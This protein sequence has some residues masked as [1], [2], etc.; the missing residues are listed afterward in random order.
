ME[1]KN[2]NEELKDINEISESS[3]EELEDINTI[4]YICEHNKKGNLLYETWCKII[5]G[6]PK[7]FRE[8]GPNNIEY[9]IITGNI[10][11]EE[12]NYPREGDLPTRVIYNHEGKM[13]GEMWR[14][15]Y[16]VSHRENGWAEIHYYDNG[17]VD[18]ILW[19]RNGLYYN[20]NGPVCVK[21]FTNGNIK[22]IKYQN[23]DGKDEFT[24]EIFFFKNGCV[25]YFMYKKNGLLHK[26]NGPALVQYCE[27][28]NIR[29]IM[30]YTNNII[31]RDDG[32]AEIQ[33][34]VNGNLSTVKWINNGS[35]HREDGP[36]IIRY[37]PNGNLGSIYYITHG[38]ENKFDGPTYITYSANNK[39]Q[40]A[41]WKKNDI[42]HRT[43]GP[44]LINIT[45]YGV[46]FLWYIDGKHHRDDGPSCASYKFNW[47]PIS[48]TYHNTDILHNTDGPCIIQYDME[49]K[50]KLYEYR[51]KGILHREYGP[52][53]I[54]YHEGKISRVY[55]YIKGVLHNDF[56]PAY[57]SKNGSVDQK[58]Y[59]VNGIIKKR[60]QMVH[61]VSYIYAPYF[62]KIIDS[63]RDIIID[64]YVE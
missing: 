6:E 42:L 38:R 53:K 1:S 21:Y 50:L 64:Y 58:I 31:H 41:M 9:S 52:A 34:Y 28:K 56:G 29:S 15:D 25:D 26:T 35:V 49:G 13:I 60:E 24:K 61:Y 17:N 59:A 36:S 63:I 23:T 11:L 46:Q 22:N 40:C 57:M 14:T 19:L 45:I 39:F 5:N 43:D 48:Y 7:K 51:I 18:T 3:D 20:D 55:Y 54:L 12:W 2:F 30:W 33:Y 4:Y 47:M 16:D 44:A 27:N 32:P 62:D 8:N 37:D 10:T